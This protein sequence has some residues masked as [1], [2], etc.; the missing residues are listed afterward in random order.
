MKA[1]VW[2]FNCI[3]HDLRQRVDLT[4]N[5]READVLI[6][7]QDVRGGPAELAR[8]NREYLH[9]PCIVVQHG[10]GATRDYLAPNNFKLLADRICVWGP[11]EARNME[12]AG[13]GDRAIVTGSPLLNRLKQRTY[14]KF[15]ERVILF[16]PV[17]TSHEEPDN[18]EVFF[19]LKRIEHEYVQEML[20]SNKEAL[21]TEWHSW[22]LDPTCATERQIPYR[23]LSRN[24]YVVSKLTEIHDVNLYQG[25][26]LKSAQVNVRH[27]E[28]CLEAMTKVSCVVGLEEGTFQLMCA[29][30]GIPCIIVDGFKYGEYGGVKDYAPE[31]IKTA[32]CRWT[33]LSDLRKSIEE[34]LETDK[35]AERRA[36]V[37][38]E[39]GNPDSDPVQNI[40][41]LAS[42][43][44]GGSIEKEVQHATVS[45]V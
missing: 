23:I 44:A 7:W 17:I 30:Y 31:I 19:E 8:L 3:L 6:L 29:Y 26:Y 27:L 18:L 10:R 37:L 34:E 20:R 15:S 42:E 33:S 2:D 38:D 14:A 4:R 5:P 41:N 35:A 40:I 24:F 45:T 13:F 12:R 9:K 36:V 32:A 1:F 39:L 16:T 43:L 28:Y 11:R 25:E 21:K 22:V